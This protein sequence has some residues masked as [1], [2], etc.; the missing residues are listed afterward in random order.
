VSA[1][2]RRLLNMTGLDQVFDIRDA[3]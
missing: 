1:N 2:M 3:A